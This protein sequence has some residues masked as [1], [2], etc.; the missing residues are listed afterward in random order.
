MVGL[1]QRSWWVIVLRGI[2]AIVLALLILLWP[3][4]T[5][6]VLIV[7]FGIYTLVD[8]FLTLISAA[9]HKSSGR[10]RWW[11]LFE[12]FMGVIAGILTLVIPGISAQFILILLALW[13]ITTG[14]AEIRNAVHLRREIDGEWLLGLGG[15]TSVL[16]GLLLLVS[17]GEPLIVVVLLSGYALIFGVL[18]LALAIRLR[19]AARTST[20]AINP[21]S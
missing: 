4:R 5:V 17:G 8:G 12:G 1:L 11:L 15:V 3:S 20:S 9:R 13:A 2:S 6:L 19:W 18:L 16:F 7:L 10:Q 21:T 14:V